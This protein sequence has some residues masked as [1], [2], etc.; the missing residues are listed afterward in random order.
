MLY[1]KYTFEAIELE[2]YLVVLRCSS[3][4]TAIIGVCTK[5][6]QELCRKL[7]LQRAIKLHKA[8]REMVAFLF[9]TCHRYIYIEMI[10]RPNEFDSATQSKF[11]HGFLFWL[12]DIYFNVYSNCF[13]FWFAQWA[14]DVF[15][16]DGIQNG[17]KCVTVNI[18]DYKVDIYIHL[19]F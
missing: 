7:D 6:K 4:L 18:D 2:W 15:S 3:G 16:L 5:K 9:W 8:L 1:V 14:W 17:V 12:F 19:L 11:F 13:F 10:Y